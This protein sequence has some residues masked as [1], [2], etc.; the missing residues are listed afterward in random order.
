M[1]YFTYRILGY[2]LDFGVVRI[3]GNNVASQDVVIFASQEIAAHIR[4]N[5]EEVLFISA[6]GE[7]AKLNLGTASFTKREKLF[8]TYQRTNKLLQT[9][10]GQSVISLTN[11]SITVIDSVSLK[12]LKSYNAV[13]QDEDGVLRLKDYEDIKEPFEPPRVC[14]RLLVYSNRSHYEQFEEQIFT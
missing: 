1:T 9:Y 2:N 11:G 4:L 14:R 7:V 10:D 6:K 12:V 13:L 8:S 3:E 5:I